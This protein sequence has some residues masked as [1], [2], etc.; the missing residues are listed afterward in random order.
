MFKY[1]TLSISASSSVCRDGVTRPDLT[2]FMAQN[3]LY[4]CNQSSTEAVKT[5]CAVITSALRESF[6]TRSK[7]HFSKTEALPEPV[8]IVGCLYLSLSV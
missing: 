2:G 6:V 5:S 8:G 3:V 4:Q 7:K 1:Y